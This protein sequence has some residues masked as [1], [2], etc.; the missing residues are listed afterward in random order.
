MGIRYLYLVRHGQYDIESQEELG[1]NL[2]GI[3]RE[4]AQATAEALSQLPIR[5]VYTSPW[6][7]A[8]ETAAIVCERLTGIQPQIVPEL[9]ELIPAIPA[10]DAYFFAMHRPNLTREHIEETRAVADEAFNRLFCPSPV[11]EDF[12]HEVVVCHGNIIRYFVCKTLGVPADTWTN[13]ETNQC[14]I[15]RCAIEADGRM[16]LI[17]MNDTGHLPLALRLFS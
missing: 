2:T 12:P 4:Q 14:G 16:R 10:R 3:G 1:G 11:Q 5:S 17:S 13:M 6:Q 7:R 8:Q 9:V 15:T